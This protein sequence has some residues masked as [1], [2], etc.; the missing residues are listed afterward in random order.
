MQK[1][2]TMADVAALAGVSKTTVSLVLNDRP[3]LP[4]S[5]RERVLAATEQLGWTPSATARALS[6]AK[7]DTIGIVL[8]RPPAITG[9]EPALD[10]FFQGVE[11][12]VSHRSISLMMRV[13]NSHAAELTALRSWWY[14]GRVDGVVLVDLRANDDRPT[15][16]GKAHIPVVGVG[17]AALRP[18]LPVAWRDDG[19]AMDEVVAYLT[20][21]GHTR[22]ARL[23]DRSVLAYARARSEAFE[24]SCSIRGLSD[25]TIND[26][27]ATHAASAQATRGLLMQAAP[28]SAIVYDNT[29]TAMAGMAV[30][31]EMGIQ[32]PKDL[33]IVAWGN[34]EICNYTHPTLSAVEA[35]DKDVGSMAARMLL[36]MIAGQEP[37]DGKCPSPV[38]VPRGSTAPVSRIAAA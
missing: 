7:T 25:Y 13:V 4:A 27:A 36:D 12:E 1:R 19:A 29:V 5:T 31:Q 22:I 15:A 3:G 32:V 14:G 26:I 34:S 10:A 8:N 6:G 11:R 2:P 9:I 17:N 21:L 37:G 28:P 20:A 24:A 33:S 38:L 30:A 18:I 35:D 16:L 23:S